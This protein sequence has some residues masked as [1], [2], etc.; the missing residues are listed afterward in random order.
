[1]RFPCHP[2][3]ASFFDDAPMRFKNEVELSA[4]PA[5]TFS[6]L[7]DAST[8]P[9]WVGGMHKAVWTSAKAGGVGSTRTVSLTMLTVD[10]QFFRWEPD[11]RFSFYLTSQSMPLTHAMAEDY[12]LEELGTATTRFTYSVAMEPRIAVAMGGP[13]ARAYFGSMF[14]GACEGLKRYV[15]SSPTVH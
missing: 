15:A 6:I 7:A 12:L 14:K 10:E 11:R 5:E 8:W 3:D 9:H 4:R 13:V 2:V 1:M